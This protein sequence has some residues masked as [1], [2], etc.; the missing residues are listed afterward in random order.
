M[1]YYFGSQERSKVLDTDGM[2]TA[3]AVDDHL[4][5]YGIEFGSN[6][7]GIDEFVIFD[8]CDRKVPIDIDSIGELIYTLTL[9]QDQC[10][11][12]REA[13]KIREKLEDCTAERVTIH[14]FKEDNDW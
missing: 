6:N 9:I 11:T 10:D 14:D 3:K 7:G 12:M 5:Y 2:F 8:G 4:F 13:D 1:K